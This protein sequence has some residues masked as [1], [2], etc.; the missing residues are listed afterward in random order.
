A[1]LVAALEALVTGTGVGARLADGAAQ[2]CQSVGRPDSFVGLGGAEL[3][4]FEPRALPALGLHFATSGQPSTEFSAFGIIAALLSGHTPRAVGPAAEL[5]RQA[6]QEAAIMDSIGLCSLPLLGLGLADLLPM[7]PAA[8]GWNLSV[9]EAMSLGAEVVD[10]ER[11]LNAK[12]GALSP[13]LPRRLTEE[14]LS[15]GAAA[16]NVCRLK[17]MLNSYP[18]SPL[19][20]AGA[21]R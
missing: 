18:L 13:G 4:P 20:G 15:S 16:G 5:C 11:S 19:F 6:Q 14:P 21:P 8:T 7:L 1:S 12:A 9:D 3:A 2:L 17:E 10:L